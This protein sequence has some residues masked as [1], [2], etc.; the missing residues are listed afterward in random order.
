MGKAEVNNLMNIE[1]FNIDMNNPSRWGV[2]EEHG[3][4]GDEQF[5]LIFYK[6]S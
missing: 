6:V 3:Y 4:P 5:P 2:Y 1:Y